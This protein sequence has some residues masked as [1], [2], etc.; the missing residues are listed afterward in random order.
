[1]TAIVVTKAKTPYK[2]LNVTASR[3]KRLS[4]KARGILF[5]LLSKP[6]DWTCHVFDLC[7]NS[8]KDGRKAIQTA[9]QEL[10]E[11]GYAK[12]KKYKEIKQN[13]F[14]GSYYEVYEESQNVL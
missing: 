7:N 12:L 9:M 8:D 5:Y 4:F 10:V 3:D 11:F 1:M 13:Q 14:R 2:L 6:T